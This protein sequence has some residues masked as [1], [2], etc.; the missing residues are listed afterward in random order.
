VTTILHKQRQQQQQLTLTAL[1]AN[2]TEQQST[3]GGA[4]GF[5]TEF[6]HKAMLHGNMPCLSLTHAQ[7]QKH[8]LRLT[9]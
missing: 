5:N 9:M 2:K 1:Y 8:G 4:K 3:D 6:V 7:P